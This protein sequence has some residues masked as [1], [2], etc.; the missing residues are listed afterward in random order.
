MTTRRMWLAVV[1]ISL[2]TAVAHAQRVGWVGEGVMLRDD[3]IRP[4]QAVGGEVVRT[5]QP[6]DANLVYQVTDSRGELLQ[7]S[8]DLADKRDNPLWV[9]RA[10]VV[11]QRDAVNY[12]TAK[13]AA[14]PEV[15]KWYGRRVLVLGGRKKR[16][17]NILTPG[18]NPQDTPDVEKAIELDPACLEWRRLRIALL[19]HK[20]DAAALGEGERLIRFAPESDLALTDYATAL[21]SFSP[22]RHELA[23]ELLNKALS[24][25]PSNEQ[26][27]HLLGLRLLLL[28]KPEDAAS[29]FTKAIE[30]NP[31]FALALSQR[32]LARQMAGDPRDAAD[33]LER[34]VEL[35]PYNA[36]VL[37]SRATYHYL[38]PKRDYRAI[39][40]DLRAIYELLPFAPEACRELAYCLA[41]YP[42]P[43]LRDGKLAVKLALKAMEL[44]GEKVEELHHV[45]LAV[46]YAEAGEF[47][48]A[49][50]EQEKVIRMIESEKPVDPDRLFDMRVRLLGFRDKQPYRQK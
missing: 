9:R 37:K 41:T 8:R 2:A 26:A 3:G 10:D 27:Y 29:H 5:G 40:R 16:L 17:G 32:G 15:G 45:T 34:A 46:A 35:A 19:S 28:R 24:L 23:L 13:I 11:R 14:E 44:V 6:L 22:D 43:T 39:D 12:F 42:D 21:L 47:D 50:S 30:L 36:P 18:L 7:L 20:G 4:G 38:T 1:V 25:N 31:V 48:K 49:V 33:D